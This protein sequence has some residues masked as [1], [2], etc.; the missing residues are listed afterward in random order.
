MLIIENVSHNTLPE[1]V[2]STDHGVIG[3]NTKRG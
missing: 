1:R 3:P 2:V